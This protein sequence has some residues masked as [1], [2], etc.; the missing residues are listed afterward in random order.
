VILGSVMVPVVVP[1]A[2]E[3]AWAPTKGEA[4]AVKAKMGAKAAVVGWWVSVVVPE[5]VPEVKAEEAAWAPTKVEVAAGALVKAKMEAKAAVVG[6]WVSRRW[7]NSAIAGSVAAL[8]HFG[9][10]LA[11]KQALDSA[12][13]LASDLAAH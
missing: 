9:S 12:T 8:D 3:A 2:E 13:P 6:W 1:E 5:A 10:V 7:P 11:G 4:A